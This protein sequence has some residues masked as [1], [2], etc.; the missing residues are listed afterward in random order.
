MGLVDRV[1]LAAPLAG[2][3]EGDLADPPDLVFR[4]G[5]IVVGD[6]FAV[7]LHR[8]MLAEVGPADQLPDHHQVDALFDDFRL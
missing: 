5:H 6:E 7:F 1:E 8:L 4:I 3:L 2:G